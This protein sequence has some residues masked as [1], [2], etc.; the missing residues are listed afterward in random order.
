MSTQSPR[1]GIS[2]RNFVT[3][4][5]GTGAAVGVGAALTGCSAEDGPSTAGPPAP[6]YVPFEGPH[7]AGITAIPVPAQGLMAAFTVIADSREKLAD[8]LAELTDEIRGLMSGRPPEQRGPAYPPVDSGILG[9]EP[10]PDDLSVVVSVGASLFDGRFGLAD[11]RPAELVQMPFLANDR[12]DPKFSL[13][14]M[15]EAVRDKSEGNFLYA[16][17]LLKALKE[18]EETISDTSTRCSSHCAN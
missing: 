11:R 14:A 15:A 16:D 12:L 10:P 5:L 18:T 8:T 13:A 7:Q 3:G 6:R 9:E 1:S 17:A 2:R 4:A